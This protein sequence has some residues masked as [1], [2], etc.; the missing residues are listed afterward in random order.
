MKY[1]VNLLILALIAF[2][3][4]ALYNSIKE[5]IAFRG[6]LDKRKDTVTTKLQQLRKAQE[7]YRE[8]K[9][10]YAGSFDSLE[11]VLTNDSI[12]FRVLEADPDDPTNPDKFI[13]TLIYFSAV[14]SIKGMGID[15]EGLKYVPY[16][17]KKST[18]E[19]M[20]DTITY[21]ST[22]VPV[23]EAMTRY[24]TFMG[25]FADARFRKYE[26]DF[27]PKAK[28]GFGSMTSPNLEGNWN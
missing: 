20:A 26:K 18:F 17:D 13:T 10:G 28:I 21:Q 25:P 11:Y 7:I 24:E 4:F 27:D 14:D 2:L 19:M 22:N 12:P 8:I 15:L 5:P 23:M 1:I 3:A 16:T 6:E 9:G